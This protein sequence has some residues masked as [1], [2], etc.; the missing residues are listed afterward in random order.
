MGVEPTRGLVAVGTV[1]TGDDATPA[2][3]AASTAGADTSTFGLGATAVSAAGCFALGAFGTLAALTTLDA[4]GFLTFSDLFRPA[5]GAL[6]DVSWE[7]P[8]VPEVA[9][10]A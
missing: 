1:C 8:G 9:V 4:L 6:L 7:T 10:S 3:G 5:G 2:A